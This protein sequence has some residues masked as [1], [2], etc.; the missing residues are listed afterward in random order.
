MTEVTREAW[1]WRRVVL[2]MLLGWVLLKL[3]HFA[4]TTY[5]VPVFTPDDD[6]E[7]AE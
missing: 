5:R 3:A 1:R 7:V 4:V 2:L 6:R